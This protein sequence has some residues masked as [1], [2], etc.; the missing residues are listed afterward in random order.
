[1]MTKDNYLPDEAY[2]RLVHE[3]AQLRLSLGGHAMIEDA[4]KFVLGEIGGVWPGSIEP[5]EKD[6]AAA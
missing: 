4:I 2:A 6:S 3:L 5:P 1:M